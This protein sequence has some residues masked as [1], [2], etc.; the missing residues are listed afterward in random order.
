[1]P[2]QVLIWRQISEAGLNRDA[3]VRGGFEYGGRFLRRIS[4]WRQMLGAGFSMEAD[5]FFTGADF[6][7]HKSKTCYS[8]LL[9]FNKRRST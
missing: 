6:L 9:S 1:M 7:A 3:D 2:G 8:V 5:L 4:I